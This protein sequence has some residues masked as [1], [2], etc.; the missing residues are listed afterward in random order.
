MDTTMLIARLINW[1]KK[2]PSQKIV[3]FTCENLKEALELNPTR[4]PASRILT[5]ETMAGFT[6]IFAEHCG[7]K[8]LQGL[9]YAVSLNILTLAGN[10]FSSLEYLSGLTKLTRLELGCNKNIKD[11]SPLSNLINLEYLE[12]D[13][14]KV[15]D[16]SPLKNLSNLTTLRFGE[17][18]SWYYGRKEI[19]TVI[20]KNSK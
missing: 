17:S 7:I 3:K 12:I 4:L 8:S 15:T 2:T 5:K 18:D 16:L 10:S 14:I 1:N 13:E 11:V 20:E 6:E 9:E 19:A